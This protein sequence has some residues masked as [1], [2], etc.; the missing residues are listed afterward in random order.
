MAQ[1]FKLIQDS[2]NTLWLTNYSL[3][4]VDWGNEEDAIHFETDEGRQSVLDELNEGLTPA[5]YVAQ[6]RPPVK[7][8][9]P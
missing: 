9:N 5:R 8:P 6:D 2:Q 1:L 7:P 3:T 4:S